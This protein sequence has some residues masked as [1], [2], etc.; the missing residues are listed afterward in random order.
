M[1]DVPSHA[2]HDRFAIADALGG[3][4]LPPTVPTCPLCGALHRDLLSI[5]T[6]IRHAWTPRRPRD[7]RVARGDFADRR[8]ALW[9]RLI[10]VFGS[11]RD[12]VTRPL[13]L[14]LATLG[15]AG[16]ILTNVS[17]G[18]AWSVGLGAAEAPASR[19][20]AD[21]ATA[22]HLSTQ[23]DGEANDVAR[24]RDPVAVISAASLAAGG[25]L[26]SLRRIASG[27]RAVR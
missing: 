6:A 13:A 15:I 5:Q 1:V 4:S 18:T 22:P 20:I 21:P 7:L 17:S 11:S 23:L 25:T 9:Q 26:L 24:E 10:D 8:Q 12:T 16:L 2:R 27:R 3:G 19:E 14:G